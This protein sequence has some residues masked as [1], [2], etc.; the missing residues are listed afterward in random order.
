MGTQAQKWARERNWNKA[1]LLAAFHQ[2]DNLIHSTSSLHEEI[3]ILNKASNLI[4]S[5]IGKWSDNNLRSKD[6]YL[7]GK[8]A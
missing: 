5:I 7:G 4:Y 3:E 6:K 8:H 2:L 1:C